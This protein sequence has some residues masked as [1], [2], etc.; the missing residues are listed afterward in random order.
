MKVATIK[1]M[2]TDITVKVAGLESGFNDS[3][4]YNDWSKTIILR[5]DDRKLLD[6]KADLFHELIEVMD[7][8][9]DLKLSH[10]TITALGQGFYQ[11]IQDNKFVTNFEDCLKNYLEGELK[12][13]AEA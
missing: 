10:Q 9:L 12:V 2:G 4:I 5:K 7:K 11:I 3:A 13:I 1:F 8:I 6:M